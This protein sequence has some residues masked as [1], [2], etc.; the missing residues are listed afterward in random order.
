MQ[1]RNFL[2]TLGGIAV[3]SQI[4]VNMKAKSTDDSDEKE[5]KLSEIT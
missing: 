5:V 1:R 3:M 4:P 2:K